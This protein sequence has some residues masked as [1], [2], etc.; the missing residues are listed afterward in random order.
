M[1]SRVPSTVSVNGQ[2]SWQGIDHQ[3][4]LQSPSQAINTPQSQHPYGSA[5][6]AA[7][8]SLFGDPGAAAS[9][10]PRQYYNSSYQY[11]SQRPYQ[12]QII[13]SYKAAD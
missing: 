2:T 12:G 8:S 7:G 3:D 4:S 1:M 13:K 11:Q 10:I 5:T 9:S 6:A